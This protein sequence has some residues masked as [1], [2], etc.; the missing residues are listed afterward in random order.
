MQSEVYGAVPVSFFQS[1]PTRNEILVYSALAS[2][3]GKAEHCFPSLASIVKRSGLNNIWDVSRAI[4]GLVKIGFIQRRQRSRSANLYILP[5]QAGPYAALPVSFLQTKPGKNILSVYAALSSYQG[6]KEHC[7]PSRLQ[8][9][10]RSGIKSLACVSRSISELKKEGWLRI[11]RQGQKASLYTLLTL[12]KHNET[13]RL[14][15]K[16]HVEASRLAEKK[17]VEASHIAEKKH[18]GASRIAEKKH[19]EASHIAEKKHNEASRLAEKKHVEASR[20]AG[21]EHNEKSQRCS[22]PQVRGAQ[23]P[24]SLI[25]KNPI[26]N[27]VSTPGYTNSTCT[28]A[29]QTQN[30]PP[31]AVSPPVRLKPQAGMYSSHFARLEIRKTKTDEEEEKNMELEKTKEEVLSELKV[32]LFPHVDSMSC[33][34]CKQHTIG[35]S[36]G[37]LLFDL[38]R[39]ELGIR[40]TLDG[41][42]RARILCRKYDGR[43]IH[44]ISSPGKKEAE[45]EAGS[46]YRKIPNYPLPSHQRRVG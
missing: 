18:N 36:N 28:S 19:V 41:I 5:K 32:T 15:E 8:I 21:N 30:R 40:P 27:P 31:S 33:W 24:Q 9:A 6:I 16:K 38:N 4:S 44:I 29:P 2:F 7:Y 37:K 10:E 1:K 39:N 22:F 20:I 12:N 34:I 46:Q 3:Q 23:F 35:Q 25:K 17:H 11:K 26:K 45:V 13:S 14:A 43:A 42:D